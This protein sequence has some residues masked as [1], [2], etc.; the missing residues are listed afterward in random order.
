MER[1]ACEQDG[2]T[3]EGLP[4]Q[5]LD[6]LHRVVTATHLA[7]CVVNGAISEAVDAALTKQ[8]GL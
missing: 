1:Q 4:E 5:L 6:N 8:A 3:A 2:G 7:R